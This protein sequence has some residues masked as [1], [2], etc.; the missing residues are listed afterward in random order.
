[1]ILGTKACDFILS[2]LKDWECCALDADG[3]S[4]GLVAA[5][6]PSTCSL[7]PFRTCV[8]IMLEGEV[9]GFEK[10]LHL[11]NVYAPYKERRKFWDRIDVSG[12]LSLENLVI[13]G[14]INL[15]LHSF[16]NWELSIHLILWLNIS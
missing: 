4:I 9:Q 14:D 11:L 7:K 16:E 2:I 5:W 6:N 12:L 10:H 13:T 1:M 8:A 15:T 3:I